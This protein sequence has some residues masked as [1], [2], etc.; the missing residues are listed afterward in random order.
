M[1]LKILGKSIQKISHIFITHMHGDHYLGLPGLVSS[2]NLLG[3]VKKLSIFGPPGV[4]EVLD[5]HFRLASGRSAFPISFTDTQDRNAEVLL[6]EGDISVSSFP[7][8]HKIPTTGFIVEAGN[9]KRKL[10]RDAIEKYSIP[11]QLRAGITDGRDFK[12]EDG[13]VVANQELTLPAGPLR[14]YAYCTDT[15]YLPGITTYIR[16]VNLLY[17][18][19]SFISADEKK[20]REVLHSTAAQAAMIARDAGAGKLLSGHFSAK[21]S[22]SSLFVKEASAI[23][24]ETEAAIEGMTY[25]IG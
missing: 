16:E 6:R 5:L 9:R 8:K 21:Y 18:E 12:M 15:V 13:T 10:R 14:S 20:A 3:R 1:R 22:D 25:E 19:A 17:H 7:L 24:P 23:F 11:K 2:M 4:R